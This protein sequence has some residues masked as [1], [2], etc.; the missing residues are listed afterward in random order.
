MRHPL[1][2]LI[3]LSNLL[4]MLN[5]RR[6]IDTEFF[7]NLSCSC[8]RVSLDGP[9]SWSLSTSDGQLLR[10]SSSRL[11]SPL[12]NFLNHRFSV[13]SLAAPDPNALLMLRVVSTALRPIL[14]LNKKTARI[15]LLSN[16]ISIVQNKYKQQVISH[17]QKN[18]VR[19][20]H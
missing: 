2:L 11:L 15:C 8:K 19:N 18:K 14:N 7:G 9:L 16:S 13:H 6:M 20:M 4:Q 3:H 12:Q 5:D 10:S 17:Y 1:T